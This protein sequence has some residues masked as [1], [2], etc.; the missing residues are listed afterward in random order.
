MARRSFKLVKDLETHFD[1]VTD[2]PATEEWFFLV[3]IIAG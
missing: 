1:C 3:A 2:S